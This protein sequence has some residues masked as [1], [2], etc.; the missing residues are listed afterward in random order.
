MV[1]GCDS[2]NPKIQLEAGGRW[3][4]I[5]RKVSQNTL[6]IRDPEIY[7]LLNE[8]KYCYTF[9]NISLPTSPHSSFIVSP[10]ITFITCWTQNHFEYYSS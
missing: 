9:Q 10:N 1:D 8:E 2:D 4:Q 7:R 6:L 5:L 3:Y